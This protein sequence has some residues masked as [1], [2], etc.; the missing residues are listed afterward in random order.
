M[1]V[2]SLILVI[3]ALLIAVVTAFM[4][5]SLMSGRDTGPAQAVAKV[6]TDQKILVAARPLPA[7]RILQA[8]DL[9]WQPWPE[10]A[11]HEAYVP[12]GA[13]SVSD[14]T[15]KVVRSAFLAGQPLT[16]DAVVGPQDRGFMAAVL[17]P[18][19]RAIT[20][21]ISSTSGVAGFVFPGDRV[22]LVVTHQV[23]RGE[24]RALQVSETVIRNVRILAIDQAVASEAGQ[25]KVGSTAT[26]EV[27]PKQVEKINVMQQLG[28]LSLS[29]RPL[30]ERGDT[31]GE[32]GEIVAAMPVD[33]TPT[34]TTAS[35]VTR[36]ANAARSS[37]GG[38]SV[39]TSAP[40]SQVVVVVR[41]NEASVAQTGAQ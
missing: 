20:V 7:G 8:D 30:A 3:A 39:R 15:G 9:K 36:F 31:I 11:V 14:M 19:M 37:G 24:A 27:T 4:A 25:A 32:N 38:G 40:R 12:E 16:K 23:E 1:N 35:E 28:G 41:G 6:A 33:T 18:G 21:S 10:D 2:R 34:Y 29:L 17:T 26:L 22:D 13:S 5:R